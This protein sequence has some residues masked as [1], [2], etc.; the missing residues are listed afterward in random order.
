MKGASALRSLACFDWE[1]GEAP[2]TD[3]GK[4]AGRERSPLKYAEGDR[5][6]SKRGDEEKVEQ[7]HI[8]VAGGKETIR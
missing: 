1:P 8:K 2:W 7:A 3:K 4:N 5:Y 6:S